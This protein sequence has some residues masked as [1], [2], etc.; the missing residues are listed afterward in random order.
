M[1]QSESK[2]K[3]DRRRVFKEV[4]QAFERKYSWLG[5]QAAREMLLSVASWNI[6]RNTDSAIR[7]RTH[8]MMAWER[9][10]IKSTMMRKMAD[11]LGDEMCSTIGKVTDAAMRGSVSSGQFTPPKPLKTP[12]IISTEFGQTDFEDELLNIFLA[13]LEEGKTNIALNKL[14]SLPNQKKKEAEKRF[15]GRINFG[16]SNEF[17]LECDFVF[18]GATYDPSKLEDDAM[19]SRFNVI[20]PEKELNHEVI[21][22]VDQNKFHVDKDTI[23]DLRKHVKSEGDPNV[24][25][26]PPS[27]LYEKYNMNVRNLRDLKAYMAARDWW[28]LEVNPKVMDEYMEYMMESRRIATMSPEDRVFDLI[29]QEPHTLEEIHRKTRYEKQLIY[30]ILQKF[31]RQHNAQHLPDGQYVIYAGENE[32]EEEDDP[33]Q[34]IFED[35]NEGN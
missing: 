5:H 25:F 15:D 32:V 26:S 12:I 13:M 10:W 24:N 20:T 1:Q 18:W 6:E 19:R 21:Q 8:V 4:V 23:R 17:D 33:K 2:V 31:M 34:N 11:L 3:Q 30:K 7:Y 28:G 29:F 22:C 16:E 14:G 35:I 9:G 27:H